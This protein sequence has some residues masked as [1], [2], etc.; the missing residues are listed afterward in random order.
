MSDPGFGTLLVKA[1]IGWAFVLGMIPLMIYLERKAS[2]FIQDRIGPNRAFIPGLGIRL[3]GAVHGLADVVKILFKED[4]VPRHVHKFYYVLAP[5]LAMF[6]AL[7][8]GAV[9]PYAHPIAFADGTIVAL[10]ALDVNVGILFLLA[11]SSLGVYAVALAGWA[12]NNKYS[13]LG[14]LRAAA[15]MISY[16]IN[17]GLS[18]AGILLV[19]NTV[20]LGD[21]V[22]QQAD[23]GHLA[24]GFLPRWGVLLKKIG[25]PAA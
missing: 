6:T 24:L 16:E 11:V 12:S 1:A 23:V 7:L 14:G 13:Q 8:V 4:L 21:M 19:Y 5:G 18:I 10:Q 3:A 20:S 2:A 17:L 25:L 15:N 9:V 22:A